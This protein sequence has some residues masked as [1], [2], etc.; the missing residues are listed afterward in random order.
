MKEL[1]SVETE[2]QSWKLREP[3]ARLER[4]LFDVAAQPPRRRSTFSWQSGSAAAIAAFAILM[5]TVVNVVQT[6]SVSH[7]ST[8]IASATIS[9]ASYAASFASVQHNCLSAPIFG[10]T[11]DGE[12]PSSNRS[13]DSFRTN[14]L[15]R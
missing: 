6:T 8:L 4:A 7:P 14:H 11:N 2:L 13:L 15:L 1:N 10:W 3:S 12:L 5:L 9:N